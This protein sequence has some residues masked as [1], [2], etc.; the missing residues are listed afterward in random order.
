MQEGSKLPHDLSEW[1][2]APD[3]DRPVTGECG[4]A[5]ATRGSDMPRLCGHGVDRAHTLD[6]NMRVVPATDAQVVHAL[7]A[8]VVVDLHHDAQLGADD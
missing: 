3:L 5:A 2:A 6:G 7:L 8:A 1:R 4:R